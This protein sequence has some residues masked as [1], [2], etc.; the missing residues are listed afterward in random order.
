MELQNHFVIAVYAFF[1]TVS[2]EE[3]DSRLKDIGKNWR[4]WWRRFDKETGGMPRN[5][6]PH[7]RQVTLERALDDTYFYLPYVRQLLFTGTALFPRGDP[8][9]QVPSLQE[10]L[11]LPLQEATRNFEPQGVI[12]LSY[13]QA[14]LEAL[15][16]LKL[17]YARVNKKGDL[18]E[19]FTAPLRLDWVDIALMPQ[20]IGFLFM[21]VRIEEEHTTL[22]RFNDLLYYVRQVHKPTIDWQLPTWKR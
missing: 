2:G 5:I 19:H 22:D 13:E 6:S 1:H 21:K 4:L 14:Y 11:D 15:H 3:V 18:T 9:Q 16:P 20:H 17:E 10:L 7:Y 12:R 8:F